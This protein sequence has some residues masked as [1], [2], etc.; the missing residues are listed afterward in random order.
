MYTGFKGLE[1][2]KG[3]FGA[4]LR[5]MFRTVGTKTMWAKD[6]CVSLWS[7]FFRKL[8]ECSRN[9]LKRYF[10]GPLA[11]AVKRACCYEAP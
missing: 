2:A 6:C 11:H 8:P 5:N 4:S 9:S 1:S 10:A 3:L 7:G